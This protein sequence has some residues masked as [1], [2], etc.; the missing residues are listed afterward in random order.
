MV[1][2]DIDYF[3]KYCY[4]N[5]YYENLNGDD[6]SFCWF[7]DAVVVEIVEMVEKVGIV[8]V[9]SWI[10]LFNSSGEGQYFE[11]MFE[12]DLEEDADEPQALTVGNGAGANFISG[13]LAF[14]SDFGDGVG[15]GN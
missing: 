10:L 1:D 5:G 11:S 6:V 8:I 4:D 13:L 15:E 3:G 2:V 14:L 7:V 9:I 12:F